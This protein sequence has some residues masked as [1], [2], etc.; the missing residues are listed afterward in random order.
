MQTVKLVSPPTDCLSISGED[1][2]KKG[3]QKEVDGEDRQ[4]FIEECHLLLK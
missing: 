2:I 3:L 1:L 4:P